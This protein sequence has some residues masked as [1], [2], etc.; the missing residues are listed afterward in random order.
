M[1]RSR[2]AWAYFYFFTFWIFKKFPVDPE[3]RPFFCQLDAKVPEID[4]NSF[5]DQNIDIGN[6]IRNWVKFYLLDHHPVTHQGIPW[7]HLTPA[8]N[9]LRQPVD[10][11][12][13]RVFHSGL[14]T[15]I[16]QVKLKQL[17]TSFSHQ[18]TCKHRVIFKMTGKVPVIR[19]KVL[20][21]QNLTQPPWA[22][23]DVN[24]Y[25]TISHQ[26]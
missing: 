19:C 7:N 8:A 23:I 14:Y 5:S 17:D 21:C 10:R 25:D 3:F 4:H 20:F 24:G 6:C 1:Y 18:R 12:E 15:E 16:E 9:N 13:K 26:Q 22:S 2:T 11:L